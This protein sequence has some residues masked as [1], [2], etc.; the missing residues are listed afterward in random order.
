MILPRNLLRQPR[1][2]LKRMFPRLKR[3]PTKQRPRLKKPLRLPRRH[4]RKPPS[5]QLRRLIKTTSR[6]RPSPS[7]RQP[8]NWRKLPRRQPRPLI[9]QKHPRKKRQLK[10]P[11]LMPKKPLNSRRNLRNRQRVNFQKI[12]PRNSP[13]LPRNLL[14]TIFPRL[15]RKPTKQRLRPR[16]P[17]KLPRR[18]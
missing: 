13:R 18:H 14:K 8:K 1:N 3:R 11:M 10:L 6:K 2:S 7:M 9:M 17:L 15:K 12:L 5:R 4:W 16:K